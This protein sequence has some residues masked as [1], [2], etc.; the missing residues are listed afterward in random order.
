MLQAMSSTSSHFRVLPFSLAH[1]EH[2]SATVEDNIRQ[3]LRPKCVMHPATLHAVAAEWEI[4]VEFKS[5]LRVCRH[6]S[7]IS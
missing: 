6:I 2:S 4:E 7:F 5:N 3:H 1:V